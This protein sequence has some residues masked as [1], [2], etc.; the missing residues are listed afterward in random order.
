MLSTGPPQ[1]RKVSLIVPT[2]AL[3]FLFSLPMSMRA[4]C[5][6]E[7]ILSLR[8]CTLRGLACTTRWGLGPLYRIIP[9]AVCISDLYQT[10]MVSL[11][12]STLKSD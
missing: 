9:W 4:A 6:C 1:G 3:K 10:K 5:R 7:A 12:A 11:P 2:L 8:T